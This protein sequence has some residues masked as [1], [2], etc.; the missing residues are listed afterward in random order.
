[1]TRTVALIIYAVILGAAALLAAFNQKQSTTF[2][3]TRAPM[4]ANHLVQSDDVQLGKGTPRAA[5]VA[6]AGRY[7]RHSI[8][9]DETVS[10]DSFAEMPSLKD[11]KVALLVPVSRDAMA[12]GVDAG[13]TVRLCAAK[14]LVGTSR[15]RAVLCEAGDVATCLVVVDVVPE[16][17]V[18]KRAAGIT[19]LRAVA[20]KAVCS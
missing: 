2:Y 10:Q 4:P 18:S 12:A 9:A 11:V 6:V 3:R 16:L 15:A 1:M 20:E 13:G 7:A 19:S 5:P 8:A 14:K 17:F